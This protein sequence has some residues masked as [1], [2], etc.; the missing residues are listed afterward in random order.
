MNKSAYSELLR[1]PRW[2]KKRLEI[3]QRDDFHCTVCGD[4]ENTLNVHHCYYEGGKPPWDYPD[5]SLITIC[6]S[7]HQWET[8]CGKDAKRDLI[9]S[10][11]KKGVTTEGFLNLRKAIDNC[12]S[13]TLDR[14]QISALCFAI[15]EPE[16][17]EAI[18][19]A[20]YKCLVER[21]KK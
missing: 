11:C 21:G 9:N 1:D 15:S 3:M 16:M 20:Q 13:S 5:A 14:H 12:F 19:V 17:F 10:L 4:G 18:I 8:D 6:E 7:C 2:Q